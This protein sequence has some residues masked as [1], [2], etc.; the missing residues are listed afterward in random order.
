[1]PLYTYRCEKCEH[2]FDVFHA[3]S[4]NHSECE[5]CKETDCIE[6][7]PPEF[8]SRLNK[9]KKDAKVGSLVESHIKEARSELEK[10]KKILKNKDY[11]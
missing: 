7:L 10:E 5:S 6:R 9:D 4:E 8:I 1:M 3:M 11:A 2:I